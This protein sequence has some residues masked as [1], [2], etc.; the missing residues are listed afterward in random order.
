MYWIIIP[1]QTNL[2]VF[3]D[4]MTTSLD[5]GR[6]TDVIYLELR[7][8]FNIVLSNILLSRLERDRL[9]GKNWLDHCIQRIMVYVSETWGYQWLYVP[10][11]AHIKI[12]VFLH[13]FIDDIDK[14]IECQ[15]RQQIFWWHQAE[16]SSWHPWI[17][18]CHPQGSGWSQDL[19]PWQSHEV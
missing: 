12:I 16:W 15:P 4:G 9:H 18:G 14:G 8:S 1:P 17:M 11:G 10:Y 6:V 5:K 3:Y 19:G 7:K 2:V 13:I